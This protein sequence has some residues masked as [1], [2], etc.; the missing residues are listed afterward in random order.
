MK[1]GQ[2][3]EYSKGNIF[4]QKSYRKWGRKASSRPLFVFLKS[5]I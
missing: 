3:K 2:S 5:F 4:L 1:F